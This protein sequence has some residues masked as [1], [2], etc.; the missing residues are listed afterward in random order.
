MV[1]QVTGRPVT[2]SATLP[3]SG[4][5]AVV[6]QSGAKAELAGLVSETGFTPLEFLDAALSGCL[7]LSVRIAAR[8]HGWG[9]RLKRVDV[10]VSHEKAVDEPSRVATFTCSFEIA[11][12]FDEAERAQ[13]IADAHR[14]CTVG[15]TFEHG[16]VI[17]D[18]VASAP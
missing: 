11:G 3:G 1:K 6:A 13:L 5:G 18:I 17:R 14:L 15:N 12:D 4:Q 9:E 8:K 16:A 10:V 2:V 7:V